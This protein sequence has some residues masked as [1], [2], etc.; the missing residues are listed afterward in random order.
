MQ[1]STHILDEALK[2]RG[3]ELEK[4]RRQ[5]IEEVLSLLEQMVKVFPFEKAYLFGSLAQPRH[6]SF[7]SDF[8][9]AVEGLASQDFIPALSFLS[10]RLGRDV[11]LIRLENFPRKERII[12]EGLSWKK[13]K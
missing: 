5:K 9:I 10:S 8:D 2:K 7:T 6:F 11:D 3:E 13:A 12:K 1:F 4:L